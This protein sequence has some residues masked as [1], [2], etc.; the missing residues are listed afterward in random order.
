MLASLM[1]TR[2]R[3]ATLPPWVMVAAIAAGVFVTALDQMVVVTALPAVMA[4]LKVPIFRLEA[5]IWV[6]TAYLL[7]YTVAMP[8]LGRLA[9]V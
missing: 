4:D 6:V 8:L 9:D 1:L 2:L 3:H 5:V 7:A